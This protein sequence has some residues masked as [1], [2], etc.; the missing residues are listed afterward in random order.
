MEDDWRVDRFNMINPP[1]RMSRNGVQDA[2]ED[3]N[4]DLPVVGYFIDLIVDQNWLNSARLGDPPVSDSRN[5]LIVLMML[6]GYLV[7]VKDLVEAAFVAWKE[8]TE[9]EKQLY[10]EFLF[11]A[12]ALQP[13]NLNL[14]RD[15]ATRFFQ[16]LHDDVANW[17][18]DVDR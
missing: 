15:A 10:D 9:S 12:V 2:W 3:L 1:D 5:A 18:A 11:R 7:R 14:V 13:P 17:E 8:V 6:R 16:N 4:D